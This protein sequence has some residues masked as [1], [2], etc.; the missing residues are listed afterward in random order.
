MLGNGR[1]THVLN[2]KVVILAMITGIKQREEEFTEAPGL[3]LI[4]L[5]VVCPFVINRVAGRT[6]M[7]GIFG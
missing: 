4:V 3:I 7:G 5:G 6:K 1:Q 2:Y